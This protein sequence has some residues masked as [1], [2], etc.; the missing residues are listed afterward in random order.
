MMKLAGRGSMKRRKYSKDYKEAA[1]ALSEQEGKTVEEAARELGIR[2]DVLRHWRQKARKAE[3][4]GL[5][6]FPGQGRPQDRELARR[7]K[8]AAAL[9]E[10]A[11]ILAEKA[12]LQVQKSPTILYE[13]MNTNKDKYTIVKMASLLGVS[14]S[15]YY[16]WTKGR[17][18]E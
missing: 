15:A 16:K 4:G 18:N 14:R 13:F 6:A 12:A 2:G 9:R 11:E 3:Q 10:A 1:I 7:R 8:E 17:G 5:P